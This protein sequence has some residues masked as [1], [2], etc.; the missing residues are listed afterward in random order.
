MFLCNFLKDF[1]D[2]SSINVSF[3]A[4]LTTQTVIYDELPS[5]MVTALVKIISN[6]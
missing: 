1:Q 2:R 4:F 6:V 3:L 5:L